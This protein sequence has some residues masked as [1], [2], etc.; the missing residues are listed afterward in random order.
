VPSR[1]PIAAEGRR[2]AGRVWA[3]AWPAAAL[4]A[5]LVVHH[6]ALRLGFVSDDY[7]CLQH[8]RVVLRDPSLL[9]APFG[10]FRPVNTWL[11]ALNMIAG[12][13]RPFGYHLFNLALF[14]ACGA[15][16]YLLLARLGASRPVCAAVA[17]LWVCSP[18]SREPADTVSSRYEIFLLA[19]WLGL[20]LVWPAPG[21]RWTR[22]RIAGA[23]ALVALSALT[24]ESWVVLP[25][26]CFTFDVC[27]SRLAPGRAL[28]RAA[29]VALAP[30]AYVAAYLARPAIVPGTYL[31]G[32]IP[33]LA[34]I[35]HALAVFLDLRE[36]VPAMPA[37][38]AAE[39][40]AAAAFAALLLLGWRW[41]I[42]AAG[43][44]LAFFLL[45]FVPILTVPF[46]TSRY[47]TIPLLG[48]LVVGHLDGGFRTLAPH[49][50][51]A[52]EAVR[53]WTEAGFH[54]KVI[55]PVP[56]RPAT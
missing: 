18:Y 44:G 37:L 54:P 5:G 9:L 56:R 25:A 2:P 53:H 15:L 24:K 20:A 55:R 17:A 50:P 52:A 30:L 29:L 48:F 21:S 51:S 14:L 3:W 11:L 27:L 4:A 33:A 10:G 28:R 40:F 32:G 42:P 34:R 16:L 36:L 39:I 13:V 38:G 45:P 26:F 19:C 1:D 47:T 6:P 35:P 22:R 8:A 41:R 31:T 49:A 46:L 23:T 7:E 12:G 43:V